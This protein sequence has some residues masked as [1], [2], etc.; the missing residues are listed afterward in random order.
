MIAS[1]ERHEGL[2]KGCHPLIEG[3]QGTFT[4]DS[5]AEKDRHKIDHLVVAEAATGKT[6]PLADL[7]QDSVLTK[8]LGK[9]GDFAEPGGR[10]GHGLGNGLDHYR[11]TSDTVHVDLL[12]ENEFV[13]PYQGDI[14][15][16]WFATCYNLVVYDFP[17]SL[18]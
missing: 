1:K 7:R 8:V 10:R 3:L 17:S 18:G 11:S 15:L 5:I 6:D 12:D 9:Q 16:S 4:T 13:L 2:R 14:L